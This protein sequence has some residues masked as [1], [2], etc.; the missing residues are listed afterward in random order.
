MKTVSVNIEVSKIFTYRGE[1]E[2]P[3]DFSD[4]ECAQALY[5]FLEG[6][7]FQEEAKAIGNVWNT[8]VVENDAQIVDF[9]VK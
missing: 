8:E 5:Q 7:T 6:E 2:V 3:E 9:D 4:L 1:F